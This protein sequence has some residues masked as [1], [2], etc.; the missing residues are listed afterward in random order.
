MTHSTSFALRQSHAASRLSFMQ[1]IDRTVIF[2][3]A[4]VAVILGS[5]L[6]LSNQAGALFGEA[7]FQPL[8]FALVYLTPLVVVTLSQSFGIRR[9]VEDGGRVRGAVPISEAVW[10]TMGRHGIPRRAVAAGL[11]VGLVNTSIVAAATLLQG[12]SLVDLPGPVLTQAFVLPIL[13]G[14][15]SQAVSYRRASAAIAKGAFV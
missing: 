5:V 8:Q 3:A 11:G 1:F 2:R 6:T 4:V 12:G 9:A 10:Q 13:F 14:L 15:V 7:A